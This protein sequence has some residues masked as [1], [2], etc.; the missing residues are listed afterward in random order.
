MASNIGMYVCMCVYV[1][2]TMRAF[3]TNAHLYTFERHRAKVD[4]ERYLVHLQ[5][6]KDKLQAS[7]LENRRQ[8]V[9][10]VRRDRTI[11]QLDPDNTTVAGVAALETDEA[12]TKVQME[13]LHVQLDKKAGQVDALREKLARASSGALKTEAQVCVCACVCVCVCVCARVCVCV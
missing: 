11:E 3:I 13:R 12:E 2:T 4:R 8:R 5:G 1:C 7:E 9:E 6:Y 10:I